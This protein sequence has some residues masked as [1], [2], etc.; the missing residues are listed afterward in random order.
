MNHSISYSRADAKQSC[1]FIHYSPIFLSYCGLFHSLIFHLFFILYFYSIK[2]L[3]LEMV[4]TR[5]QAGSTRAPRVR[6]TATPYRRAQPRRITRREDA[7]GA[8]SPPTRRV[9]GY[10]VPP[11]GPEAEN[12]DWFYQSILDMRIV[13]GWTEYLVGWGST[14]VREDRIRPGETP[15]DEMLAESRLIRDIL[16]DMLQAQLQPQLQAQPN[17]ASKFIDHFAMHASGVA[18]NKDGSIFIQ[19]FLEHT[20]E[21]GKEIIFEKILPNALSLMTHIFGNYVIQKLFER[22]STVEKAALTEAIRGNI[23]KLARDEHGC[24]VVEKAFV[25][26]DENSQLELLNEMKGDDDHVLKHCSPEQ[27]RPVLEALVVNLK[28]LVIDQYGKYVIQ[29]IIVNGSDDERGKIIEELKGEV[30]TLVKQEHSSVVLQ[31]LLV[32]ANNDHKNVLITEVCGEPNNPN[33]PLLMMMKDQFA[34]YVVQKMLDV[35]DAHHRRKM[36]LIIQPHSPTLRNHPYGK[37]VC[38]E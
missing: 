18:R 36:C 14:W 3:D 25:S 2:L 32:F 12:Q 22:G 26:I 24:R 1:P 31:K 29:H 10:V 17:R 27:K 6:P 35:A 21:K 16:K 11:R 15:L 20:S 7:V 5:S 37:Y 13:E 9:G 19:E 30:L 23:M 34:N 8:S 28:K 38:S 4:T 33:P